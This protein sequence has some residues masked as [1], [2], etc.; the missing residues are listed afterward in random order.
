MAVLDGSGSEKLGLERRSW[1]R[2]VR[3]GRVRS[4]WAVKVVSGRVRHVAER[5]GGLGMVLKL[6]HGE[7]R[8]DGRGS[9][10]AGGQ[11]RTGKLC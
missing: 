8:S 2:S 9:F 11:V 10:G 1:Q 7:L 5:N 3:Y 6:G 4:G